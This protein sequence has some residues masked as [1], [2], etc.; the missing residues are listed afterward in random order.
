MGGSVLG[1]RFFGGPYP[2]V[3][4]A[5]NEDLPLFSVSGNYRGANV[6]RY[7]MDQYGNTLAQWFGLSNANATDVFPNLDRFPTRT[8]G[9]LS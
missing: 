7:S 5:T 4:V 2:E 8:L 9:F 1:G 6:P 3:R